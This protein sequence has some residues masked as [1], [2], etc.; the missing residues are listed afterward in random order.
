MKRSIQRE[1]APLHNSIKRDPHSRRVGGGLEK[2]GG[3]SACYYCSGD[4]ERGDLVRSIM[5]RSFRGW[6]NLLKINFA[7]LRYCII[8]GGFGGGKR[9]FRMGSERGKGDL[10]VWFHA[11][12][13]GSFGN[14]TEERTCTEGTGGKDLLMSAEEGGR[15]G[16]VIIIRWPKKGLTT[17]YKKK[18]GK[19]SQK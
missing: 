9:F 2:C 17:E 19:L 3:G 6:G 4:S 18:K 11:V 15:G 5:R 12:V 13:A 8:R 10:E 7:A 16:S 14:S 1:Q